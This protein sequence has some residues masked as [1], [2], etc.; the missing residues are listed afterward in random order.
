MMMILTTTFMALTIS[1]LMMMICIFTSK[2][3]IMDRE[4]MSPFECGFDPKSSP[5][6]PFSIQF[7]LVATLFLVFDVEI[8]IIIPMIITFKMSSTSTWLFMTTTFIIILLLG[9]Y[10]EWYN[11][12]LEW[13]F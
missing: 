5:R 10:Y 2:K 12:M 4:K 9:L 1:V 3:S 7:F 13:S 11:N 8:T 6:M